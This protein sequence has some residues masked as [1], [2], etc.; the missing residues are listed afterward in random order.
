MAGDAS[1]VPSQEGVGGDD[2]TGSSWAGER[3]GDG[4]EQSP[5]I[6]VDSGSA[7]LSAQHGELVAEHDD[8]EFLGAAGS[9][10][11]TGQAGDEA[12]ENAR[13]SRSASAVFPLISG[14]DRIF[15]PHRRHRGWS[16]PTR[17]GFR[18]PHAPFVR[19][20]VK[21]TLTEWLAHLVEQLEEYE[22]SAFT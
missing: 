22:E 1:S 2:P 18:A 12:V 8:L 4:A 20:V 6:V 7:E 3:G 16:A 17:A 5:I 15:G 21:A 19:R 10:S 14:H 13:H 11:E 9:D